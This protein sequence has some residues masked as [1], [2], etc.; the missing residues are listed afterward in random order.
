[1]QIPLSS[2]EPVFI[3]RQPIFN[4]GLKVWGYE[5]LFRRGTENVANV[6]DEDKATAKVIVD[7]YTL[8]RSSMD[9]AARVLINFPENLILS[10]AAKAL[11]KNDCIVEILEHVHPTND[12]LQALADLKDKGFKLALDDFFGEPSMAPFLRL[13]DIVKVDIL[14][15]SPDQICEL[16]DTLQHSGR[17]LLAEKVE[18]KEEFKLTKSLG[19]HLFQGYYFSK[20][21]IVPG[22][23][24]SA[25]NAGKLRLL[26]ELTHDDINIDHLAR[27]VSEDISLSY[28]LLQ[29]I[30]SARFSMRSKVNSIKQAVIRLGLNPLREWLML[31]AM[32]DMAPS[33][34][35]KEL[36]KL[37]ATRGKFFELLGQNAP[38]AFKPESLF[39][40]GLLSKLDTLLGQPMSQTIKSMPLADDIRDALNGE[41][42]EA[43]QFLDMVQFLERGLFDDA[44]RILHRLSIPAD[45]T[46]LFHADAQQWAHE[47]ISLA[48]EPSPGNN[49]KH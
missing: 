24:I 35:T 12:V 48:P 40:L 28:R 45:R 33:P 7:G 14:G 1:M 41:K 31:V 32:S 46:A 15:K 21:E 17:V 30:N 27:I 9:Q 43:R 23:K 34:R 16:F 13:A 36:A 6:I 11:S 25:G 20:P 42:N 44:S 4:R 3:A 49:E 47:I 8:A 29:Y 19:F 18:T 38:L 22:R 10:G 5:L 37:S 2:Y 39:L 26:G